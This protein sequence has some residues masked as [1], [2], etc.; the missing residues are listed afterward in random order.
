MGVSDPEGFTR[1]AGSAIRVVLVLT[2]DGTQRTVVIGGRGSKKRL[3]RQEQQ[4]NYLSM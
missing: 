1:E 4:G 3:R 2:K